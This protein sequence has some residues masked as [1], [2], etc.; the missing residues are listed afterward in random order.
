MT[1]IVATYV[2]ASRLPE[3]RPTGTPHARAK[4]GMALGIPS[5]IAG[6]RVQMFC[7]RVMIINL[8]PE[9][10]VVAGDC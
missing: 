2:I 9:V 5:Q 3:P 10:T 4:M 6:T 7:G 1:F 8:C